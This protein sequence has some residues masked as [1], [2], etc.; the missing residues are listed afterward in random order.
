MAAMPWTAKRNPTSPSRSS[1]AVRA[2]TAVH[3]RQKQVSPR[4][5]SFV[6][7]ST[8]YE[9][10]SRQFFGAS[11]RGG[12]SSC[13]NEADL[14]AI[15]DLGMQGFESTMEKISLQCVG[16]GGCVAAKFEKETGYSPDCAGCFGTMAQCSRDKCWSKCM[17]GRSKKCEDCSTT[18]CT[19]AFESCVGAQAAAVMMPMEREAGGLP[20]AVS[21]R[22]SLVTLR[23][24]QL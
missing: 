1:L 17:W 10:V 14:A 5:R 24:M 20:A 18:K 11:E 13:A 3:A 2:P 16:Q 4:I 22:P 7:A 12:E 19:P 9:A 23:F 21:L 6:G 8:E 15:E